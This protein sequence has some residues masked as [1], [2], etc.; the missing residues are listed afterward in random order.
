VWSFTEE[1]GIPGIGKVHLP[2]LVLKLFRRHSSLYDQ[3]VDWNSA[4]IGDA[5]ENH[6][7]IR[8]DHI[9]ITKF[10]TREDDGYGKILYA[11]QISLEGTPEHRGTYK[12][13]LLNLLA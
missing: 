10:S 11:I 6:G 5:R 8:A 12:F 4:I 13:K 1:L 9:G 2:I 3:V 7:T